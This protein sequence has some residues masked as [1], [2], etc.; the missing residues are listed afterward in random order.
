M[1]ASGVRTSIARI[2]VY[3]ARAEATV[4]RVRPW[5][6]PPVHARSRAHAPPCMPARARW[7]TA[8]RAP[9]GA[10]KA[11]P[12]LGH[13]SPR[14]HKSCPSQRSPEFAPS[15]PCHRPPSFPSLGRRGPHPPVASKLRQP[16]G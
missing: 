14:A 5:L 6:T 10:Y 4:P 16:L 1:W 3:G 15:T 2:I 9:R 13:T 8:A 11:A 12:R 7:S